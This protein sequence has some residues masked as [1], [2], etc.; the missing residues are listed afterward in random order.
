MQPVLL[1]YANL[2]LCGVVFLELLITFRKNPTLKVYFMLIVASLFVMNFYAIYGITNRGQFI[3]AKTMRFVYSISTI[4]TLMYLVNLKI[5]RWFVGLI[6]FSAVCFT[7]IRIA[8]YDEIDIKA[9]PNIPNHVFSIGSEFYSPKT[10]WRYLF[11]SLAFVALIIAYYYYRRLLMKLNVE[12]AHYK[13][14]S[15]WIISFVIPF[16]LLAIFGILGNLKIIDEA[17][18][19]YLFAIFSC[20]TI[21][22]FVLRPRF[23]DNGLLREGMEANSLKSRSSVA[24]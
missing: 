20:T 19:S 1:Y 5:P 3:F 17:L 21:C 22:S 18:S 7:S 23:L 16:F 9:F 15:R 4:L 14:L 12:S 8:Y 2:V 6:I 24:M 10:G 13:H 11:L